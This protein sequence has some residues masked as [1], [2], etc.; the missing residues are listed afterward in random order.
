M[1]AIEKLP[2]EYHTY[3][4]IEQVSYSA[5]QLLRADWYLTSPYNIHTFFNK[6]VLGIEKLVT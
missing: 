6:L 5:H 2:G 3:A 1:Q 4:E